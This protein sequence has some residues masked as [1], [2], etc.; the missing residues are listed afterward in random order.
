VVEKGKRVTVM[1][2]YIY[3]CRNPV[4]S[5]VGLL[6]AA[7]FVVQAVKEMGRSCQHVLGFWDSFQK[8]LRSLTYWLCCELMWN[9]S[10]SLLFSQYLSGLLKAIL[11]QK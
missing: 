5:S 10:S 4:T 2:A 11:H 8:H 3:A 9:F 6:D 7:C 1:A